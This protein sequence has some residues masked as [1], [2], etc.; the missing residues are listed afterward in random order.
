[1]NSERVMA[2]AHT[3]GGNRE[4]TV[5][6]LYKTSCKLHTQ[7]VA[8]APA[9]RTPTDMAAAGAICCWGTGGGPSA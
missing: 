4:D 8:A 9:R 6:T 7:Y 3:V 2:A 5:Y 1:M